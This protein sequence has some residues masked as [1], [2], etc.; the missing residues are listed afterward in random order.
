M[1]PL[2][3]KRG[4]SQRVQDRRNPPARSAHTPEVDLLLLCARWPLRPGDSQLIREHCG[5]A[6]D[7]PR[8]L[9]LVQHHRLVPLIFHNLQASIGDSRTPEQQAVL[10]KLRQLN[11]ADAYQSLRSLAEL[12]RVVQEFQT[13]GISVRVLKGLPLAQSV[14]GDLGLRS[15]GDLDLLIDESSILDADR[16][17]RSFG[18]QGIFQVERFSRKRLV[19]Y[20]AHWKDLAYVNRDTGIEVDLHWR[21]FRNSQMPGTALCETTAHD[22]VSFGNFQA[23]TLPSMEGLLYLCVHGTLDGWLYLKSLVDVAAQVR[24]MSEAELDG[25]AALATSYGVLPELSGALILVRRYLEMDHWS[26]QLL[27]ES[28]TTVAHILRYAERGLEG[29]SFLADR[30]AIPIPATIAFEVGLRR[31][32]R[33]RLELLVRVLFRARMWE[34]IPLPD[35]LFGLYPLLSPFEWLLFRVRQGPVRPA[36]AAR[37]RPDEQPGEQR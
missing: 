4:G 9:L 2:S 26:G 12:R 6:V 36:E 25:L 19:F 31:S 5:R 7:W 28:D 17:L 3:L 27:P 35:F 30:D 21:G 10:D 11:S 15:V 18:Y 29:G 34:T 22:T 33:Y 32:L 23:K 8:F 24:A 1:Y 37:A 20:R 16:I 14:F 13:H